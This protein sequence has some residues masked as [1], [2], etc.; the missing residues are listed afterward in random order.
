MPKKKQETIKKIPTKKPKICVVTW[1]HC[2]RNVKLSI[3]AH[4]LGYELE[5]ITKKEGMLLMEELNFLHIYDNIRLWETPSQLYQAIKRSDADVFWC[6]NEPDLMANFCNQLKGKRL[7]IHDIHDLPSL[8]VKK[9]QCQT[10]GTQKMTPLPDVEP[11]ER[12]A[13]EQSDFISVPTEP[14]IGIINAKYPG[15]KN[16][17]IQ[18][19]SC[20][21]TVFF[22]DT[23]LPRV[24]GILYCGQVNVPEMKSKLHYRDC[25]PLFQYLTS[26][27]IASH[28][29]YT[30]PNINTMPYIQAGACMYGTY[31]MFAAIHQY[32]RYDYGFVGSNVDCQEIQLCMP[33]KLWDCIAAGIPLLA[34]N[35][36]VS[37]K[38]IIDNEFGAN[39]QGVE[40]L[41]K[42]PW[43][44]NELWSKCRKNVRDRRHEFTAENEV[45]KL[46]NK[47]GI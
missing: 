46:F 47:M 1:F 35:A 6:H 18:I 42:V 45:K 2:L 26:L 23:D 8:H 11:E 4:L 15:T 21:P 36:A 25:L 27:G 13:I 12:T 7:V 24:S 38:F 17:I 28:V 44:D 5:L 31:R 16:K 41:G 22:P 43:Y 14:Y 37:G 19:N 29:Y 10:C 33:N 30:N 34:L 39:V 3:G 9:E 20:S 32:T 40:N